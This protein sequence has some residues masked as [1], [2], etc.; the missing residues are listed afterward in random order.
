MTP[1]EYIKANCRTAHLFPPH[2]RRKRLSTR[3]IVLHSTE[4]ETA[5]STISWFLSPT[6]PLCA[7]YLI[8]TDGGVTQFGVDD[9]SL[10]HTGNNEY[11]SRSMGIEHVGFHTQQ[12]WPI[13][14]LQ[15]SAAVAAHLLHK[16]LLTTSSIILHSQVPRATHID[17]GPYFPL[18]QYVDMINAYHPI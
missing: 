14:Q 17:P 2:R 9:D 6:Q 18:Q 7:H 1:E 5:A 12:S 3:Y 15:A 13:K 16:Y 10:P 8:D 4:A 11:N